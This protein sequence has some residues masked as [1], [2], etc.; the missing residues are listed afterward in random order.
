MAKRR[1]A[2]STV[3]TGSNVYVSFDGLVELLRGPLAQPGM[4]AAVPESPKRAVNPSKWPKL[5]LEDFCMDYEIPDPLRDKL[6]KLCVQGPHALCWISDDDLRR[7]GGLALG[8]LETLRD[9]EQRWKN[10]CTWDN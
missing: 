2:A 4:R 10:H 1:A 6:Q 9:A 8:E 3:S 7:E 5:S